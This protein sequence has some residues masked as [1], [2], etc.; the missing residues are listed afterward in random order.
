MK[1]TRLLFLF[2]FVAFFVSAQVIPVK[3]SFQTDLARVISDYPN[4]FKNIKGELLVQ[5]PQTTD[6]QSLVIL[7]DAEECLLTGYGSSGREIYSWHAQILQTEDFAE[8]DKK[9]R[10]L[11]HH[12]NK[13]A[14]MIHGK[15]VVFE[16]DFEAPSE[17]MKFTSIVFSPNES[18]GEFK[19][20]KVELLLQADML[21]WT[22]KVLVYDREREDHERGALKE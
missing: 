3:N 9:F 20:L 19:K 1:K 5:N 10:L 15:R 12:L 4:R 14:V 17:S 13:L 22:L 18:D 8:A 21:E 2:L 16:G 7:K 6:Y 11:Y